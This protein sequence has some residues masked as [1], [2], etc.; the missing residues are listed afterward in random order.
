MQ[1]GA[2][3]GYEYRSRTVIG[4]WPLVHVCTGVDPATMRPRVAKG[5]IAVGNTA[6]GVIAAGGVACGLLSFGGASVGI[7]FALGGA[8]VGVGVSIGG[9]AI[10]SVALGGAA[11]GFVYA[12]GGGAIGPAI[13]DGRRCDP[14]ALD[15]A[16]RWL[17]FLG[18]PQSCR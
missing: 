5:I 10:G 18:L 3:F 2:L 7:L 16:R 17:G 8:A 14:A 1:Q 9:L 13:I 6:V 12:I 11:V 15:F 4:T